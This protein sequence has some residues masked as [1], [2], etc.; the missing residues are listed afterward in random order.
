VAGQASA[1]ARIG[2]VTG[3]A[4]AAAAAGE[5]TVGWPLAAD[6][7]AAAAAGLLAAEMLCRA[8]RRRLGGLTGDIFGAV[9]EITTATTLVVLA[10]L[11]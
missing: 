8:A 9:V 10:V 6:L 4:V 7:L 2:W 1:R 11:V 5:L 3:A